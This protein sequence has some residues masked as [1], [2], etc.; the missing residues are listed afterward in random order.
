[1]L[2]AN[3]R[4]EGREHLPTLQK[5]IAQAAGVRKMEAISEGEAVASA[6]EHHFERKSVV[7]E[8]LLLRGALIAGRGRVSLEELR[9]EVNRKVEIGS[10]LRHENQVASK[11]AKHMK[12]LTSPGPFR[13]ANNSRRWG[14]LPISKR[15]SV[16]TNGLPSN[17]S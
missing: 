16:M 9:R 17:P 2:K 11:Q 14:T 15:L 5:V 7:D 12:W 6:A 4:E 1:M 8:R 10:L 13:D 3:W